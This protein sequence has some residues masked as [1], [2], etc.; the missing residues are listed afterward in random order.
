MISSL[1]RSWLASICGFTLDLSASF[2]QMM[3]VQM[4]PG[5]PCGRGAIR[6]GSWQAR[7]GWR[8]GVAGSGGGQRVHR[9]ASHA[10]AGGSEDGILLLHDGR[11]RPQARWSR[12]CARRQGGARA[13][14]RCSE[15]LAANQRASASAWAGSSAVT[16]TSYVTENVLALL[17][18]GFMLFLRSWRHP[19]SHAG[20]LQKWSKF[21]HL[22]IESRNSV[23]LDCRA[24][25]PDHE[26]MLRFA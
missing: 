22:E 3:Y 5:W 25:H 19:E 24:C 15:S 11:C 8:T 21:E 9:R 1:K 23:L 26:G 17:I 4:M 7:A 14:C 10:G 12:G 18:Y 13:A 6:P 20:A 2:L 16:L